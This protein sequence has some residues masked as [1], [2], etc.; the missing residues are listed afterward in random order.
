MRTVSAAVPGGFKPWDGKRIACRTAGYQPGGQ[1]QALTGLDGRLEV[2]LAGLRQGGVRPAADRYSRLFTG[3]MIGPL[4]RLL[5][6]LLLGARRRRRTE[7]RWRASVRI[8]RAG[9]PPGV[10]AIRNTGSGERP[11]A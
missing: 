4:I 10:Q 2:D 9:G 7:R 8:R 3:P 5:S 11:F 6:G 1:R